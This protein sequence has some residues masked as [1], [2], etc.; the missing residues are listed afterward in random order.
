MG[1]MCRGTLRQQTVRYGLPHTY[2]RTHASPA[3][4]HTSRTARTTKAQDVT[5]NLR[6]KA[7][8]RCRQKKKKNE[9]ASADKG[10]LPQ[11]RGPYTP[12][13]AHKRKHGS[14][15]NGEGLQGPHH[16]AGHRCK[17]RGRGGEW[18]PCS[19][20]YRNALHDLA[21]MQPAC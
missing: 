6:T 7:S 17:K 10:A 11:M 19:R 14:L 4:L 12:G 3:H 2:T 1:S 9:F 15:V 18:E 16:N 20:V 21:V 8:V 13:A 5:I